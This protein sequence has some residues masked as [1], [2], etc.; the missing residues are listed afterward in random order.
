MSAYYTAN[1]INNQRTYKLVLSGWHHTRETPVEPTVIEVEAKSPASNRLAGAGDAI[2]GR[3][4][5]C[6]VRRAIGVDATKHQSL[7]GWLHE[8]SFTQAL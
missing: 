5:I 8:L 7:S 6:A 3:P 2:L 4:P 1:L